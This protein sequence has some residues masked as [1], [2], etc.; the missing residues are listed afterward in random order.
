MAKTIAV[1][2]K[3]E[4]SRE[5]KIRAISNGYIVSRWNENYDCQK[6]VFAKTKRDAQA[7]AVKMLGRRG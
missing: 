3:R 6:E 1:K 4:W 7:E 2:A 5:V